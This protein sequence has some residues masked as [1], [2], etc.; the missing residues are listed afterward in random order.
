MIRLA[1]PDIRESDI[2]RCVEVL[3][4][5][6]LVQG[7]G[8]E[9]F[10]AALT[11]YAGF[12]E[13]AVVSSG[14]AALHLAL[15]SAGIS[16][17]DRV[18]VADF[19]FPATANAVE[20][21]GASSIFCDVHPNSYTVTPELVES[22]LV[23]AGT[24]T[25]KA[26]IVV[27]EFGCP[28]EIESICRLANAAGIRVIEDAACALG[29]IADGRHVGFYGDAACFSFHPRKAITTGEGGAVISRNSE[30]IG[31]V[32]RLRN[33]GISRTDDGV[34]FTDAGLNYRMTDFQAALAI[35]QLERYGS[36]LVRRRELVAKYHELLSG[37][38]RFTLPLAIEGHSWQS[39]MI[40]LEPGIDRN[41]VVADMRGRGVETNLGAQA[42]HRLDYFSRKYGS[43]GDSFPHA[44]RLYDSGLVLPLYSKLGEQQ[45]EEIA[46]TLCRVLDHV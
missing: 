33:H 12:G 41:R 22:C 15:L 24:D 36:E 13:C 20:N 38:G 5:G 7:A 4:S 17:G 6:N 42:L 45:L 21:L 10:E 44:S 23:S 27:H 26:M 28:A 32:R 34:D 3:N 31:R 18:L 30:L 19:T 16:A 43:A 9:A 40:V 14:T 2:A 11:D 25:V 8:V 39:Y 29:T 37:D 1:S 46:Q 35:G